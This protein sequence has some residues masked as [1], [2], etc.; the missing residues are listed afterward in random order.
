MFGDGSFLAGNDI[1]R[2]VELSLDC[3]SVDAQTA[4]M[5]ERNQMETELQRPKGRDEDQVD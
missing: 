3:E 4:Q 2:S 1:L 5:W